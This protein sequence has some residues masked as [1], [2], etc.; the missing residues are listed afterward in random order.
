[1]VSANEL[2]K[3]GVQLETAKGHRKAS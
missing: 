1:L 3:L 2:E